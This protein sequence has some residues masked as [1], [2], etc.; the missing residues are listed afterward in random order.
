MAL[1]ASAKQQAQTTATE[2]ELTSSKTSPIDGLLIASSSGVVSVSAHSRVYS[3]GTTVAVGAGS[4]TGQAQGAFVRVYYNDA[5]RA[6]GAVTYLATTAE[7]TQTGN[8]HVVGAV[9]VPLEG[10]PPESGIGTTPPGYIRDFSF[11][12]P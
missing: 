3:N 12:L 11:I 8:V 5:A 9:T 7:I 10:A 2:I 4:V 6:G 1:A